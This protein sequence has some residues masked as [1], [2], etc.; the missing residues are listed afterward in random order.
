M[1]LTMK[2]YIGINIVLFIL[3]SIILGWGYLVIMAM[4]ATVE[5]FLIFFIIS[6]FIILTLR[7]MLNFKINQRKFF[8]FFLIIVC[9]IYF[10]ILVFLN[11]NIHIPAIGILFLQTFINLIFIKELRKKAIIN[12]IIFN[13]MITII[14]FINY[15]L[16]L[17][18]ITYEL[19]SI[20]NVYLIIILT[21]PLF[22]QKILEY[23][24][25]RYTIENID[26]KNKINNMSRY[27]FIN[28]FSFLLFIVSNDLF[29][30]LYRVYK[31]EIFVFVIISVL[32]V[33]V[34][35]LLLIKKILIKNRFIL[36]IFQFLLLIFFIAIPIIYS[37][38]KIHYTGR[39]EFMYFEYIYL[40]LFLYSVFLKKAIIISIINFIIFNLLF[41]KVFIGSNSDL[42]M[43]MFMIT[44]LIVQKIIEYNAVR[45]IEAKDIY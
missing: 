11:K 43:K 45:E 22:Y 33:N 38:Q 6:I 16:K 31:K 39:Y 4:G 27:I 7:L 32:I 23:K 24:Y 3:W 10:A 29:I 30:F 25:V 41:L 21:I 37:K 1:E 12:F 13:L 9:V 36:L 2:K 19:N 5:F 18:K 15:K 28:I 42:D 26:I 8:N 20:I 35:K 40:S 44:I 17:N 14:I 34:L